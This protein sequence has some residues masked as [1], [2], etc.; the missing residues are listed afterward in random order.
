MPGPTSDVVI[1]QG[2]VI[3]HSDVTINTLTLGPGVV[4][5]VAPGYHLTILH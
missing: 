2:S 4:F 5:T 1:M 3:L